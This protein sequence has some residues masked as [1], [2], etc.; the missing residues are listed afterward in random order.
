MDVT[1][2]RCG[3]EYEFEE[4]LVSDRGTRVK[5]TACGHTFQIFRRDRDEAAS[6]AEPEEGTR[7]TLKREDGSTETLSSLANLQERILARE[8]S[9][10][11]ALA[12]TGEPFKELGAIAEL[13]PF[14]IEAGRDRRVRGG[15]VAFGGSSAQTMPAPAPVPVPAAP[16]PA[17]RTTDHG[18]AGAP[19]KRTVMG[20]AGPVAAAVP[21]EPMPGAS[22]LREDQTTV[23]PPADPALATTQTAPRSDQ[24]TRAVAV[25]AAAAAE[26]D[27]AIPK[28][29]TADASEIED[30]LAAR[31]APTSRPPEEAPR[32]DHALYIDEDDDYRLPVR[33]GARVGL[34]IFLALLVG[35]GAVA[36]AQRDRLVSL[37]TE[38]SGGSVLTAN[39]GHGDRAATPPG[40][41]GGSPAAA[42]GPAHPAAADAGPGGVVAPD[43]GRPPSDAGVGRDAGAT[44][45][46]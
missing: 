5:C 14:F 6:R 1:C 26:P 2:E 18:G 31:R 25:G 12:R 43:G 35:A 20:A 41:A 10:R 9:S 28:T 33:S 46:D 32:S 16:V 3:A 38:L 23:R 45:P 21:A 4:A 17:H 30:V 15:T 36:Y 29:R 24:P 19:R 44:R 11:D 34:W 37:W 13:R 42:G 7:W 39:A 40:G 22:R 27:R 8:V